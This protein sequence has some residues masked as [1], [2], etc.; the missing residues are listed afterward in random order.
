MDFPSYLL[1][2]DRILNEPEHSRPY[3][4]PVFLNYVLLNRTRM[5]RWMKNGELDPDLV[6]CIEKMS[7]EQHWILITEP[8]CGD[9]AHTVPFIAR[10]AQKNT[11]ITLEIQ[12][13]DSGSEIERYLTNGTRSIPYLVIRD[14]KEKDLAQWGPRPKACQELFNR[15]RSNG[16]SPEERKALIQKWYNEDRGRRLQTELLGIL[17]SLYF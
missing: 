4:D 8:W 13:R 9:A 7:S 15:L 14:E 2:F 6:E 3:D 17:K 1:L 5:I 10:L 12:L 11:L 16:I